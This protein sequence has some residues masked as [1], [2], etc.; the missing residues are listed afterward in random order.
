MDIAIETVKIRDCKSNLEWSRS[1]QLYLTFN[2]YVLSSHH[3]I[4]AQA[5][6]CLPSSQLLH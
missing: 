2:S 4:R 1:L 3:F 5:L 6:L